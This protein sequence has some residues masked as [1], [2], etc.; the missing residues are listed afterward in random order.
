[1]FI[2]TAEFNGQILIQFT[3]VQSQLKILAII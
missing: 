3:D 2:T 1:M